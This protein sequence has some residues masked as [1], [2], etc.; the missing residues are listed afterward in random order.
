MEISADQN[1][2]VAFPWM[3]RL[4][5]AVMLCLLGAIAPAAEI[6]STKMAQRFE[7]GKN[8]WAFQPLNRAKPLA[9]S[10]GW[11]RND[12]D[13]FILAELQ[14]KGLKPSPEA[15]RRTLIRRVTL[16]LTG[17][18]PTPEEVEAF[19]ADSTKTAYEKVVDRLLASPHYGER[20]GRHW[21][22]LA[23]YA[24]SSGFHN[25]LDRP[26][27]W[28]YRD[29]VIQSFNEDKP[30]A[31]FIAEQLA[32]DELEGADETTVIATGFCRNGPSNEDNMGN[33]KEQYRLD[34]LD[35]VISTTSTVFLGLT[36]GCARC[37]DHKYDPVTA[38]DYYRLLA[39]FNGTV[40]RGV[41]AAEKPKKGEEVVKVLALVETNAVVRPTHLLRRGSLQNPGPEMS[42][43]A[44]AILT[45]GRPLQFPIPAADATS[46]QRRRTLAEWIGAPDN[47]LTWRVLANRLWQ[48][49]FGVGIVTTPGNFGFAGE[50]PSHPALLDYLAGEL[51]ANGGRMKPMH[52]MMVLSATYRQTSVQ[53]GS[54]AERD[55]QNTLLWRMNKRRMEAET[56]RDSILAVSGKLNPAMGG[57]GFKPRIRADLLTASQRNK[58]PALTNEGP[59]QWRRSV[60]IYVKRQ[61]LMPMMELFDAPTTTDSCGQRTESVVPTQALVLMNDEFVEDQAG[62]LARRAL[63]AS[64]DDTAV[65][66]RLYA[67]AMSRPAGEARRQ[68]AMTFVAAR[69]AAYRTES[70]PENDSRRRALTDLAHV[71]LNS[72]EFIFI[73]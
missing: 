59:A 34:E 36:V 44:P 56:V 8:H 60:Y 30:Y 12:I 41:P 57:P 54:G 31:R 53:N 66:N 63:S 69:E 48:H 61:L 32:G 6:A 21:L 1:A 47:A 64:N 71:L 73:E 50:R 4:S 25:D 65:V 35:D 13:R 62:F 28:R 2:P 15:D 33:D 37:H 26:Q 67:L 18:P 27:A 3:R 55:P 11:A 16:D 24:D 70:T 23:R 58:W 20:W 51:V 39:V 43:G 7:A 45:A 10:S 40:K 68:Q 49:H 22:D 14:A 52:R 9:D 72:S 5:T 29:Y 19:A 42:P 17:L 38:E 46:S